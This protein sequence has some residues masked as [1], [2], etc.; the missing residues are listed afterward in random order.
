LKTVSGKAK[1]WLKRLPLYLFDAAAVS[2][3]YVFMNYI[4]YGD[5]TL[6]S[7]LMESMMDRSS[8]FIVA[9]LLVFKLFGLYNIIWKYAGAQELFRCASA[10]IFAGIVGVGIERSVRASDSIYDGF[11]AF[12]AS[13]LCFRNAVDHRFGRRKPHAL[14]AFTEEE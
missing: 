8:L 3:A 14:Q 13:Y 11:S 1:V 9:Y 10:A 4:I 5:R 6:F 7:T 2:F 12:A